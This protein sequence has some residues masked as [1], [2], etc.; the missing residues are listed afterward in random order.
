MLPNPSHLEAI[1]P[2]Q[3]GIV[4]ALQTYK[5]ENVL[6]IQ[7]HGDAAFSGQ[8]VV[9]ETLQMSQLAG[10]GVGGT[11]HLIVNNQLGYTATAELGRSARYASAPARMIGAPILH[12]NGDC[13]EEVARA[14]SIAIQ[15]QQKFAR[16]VII[17]LIC[18]RRHGHNELDEPFFTQPVMYKKIRGRPSLPLAYSEELVQ[19]DMMTLDEVQQV[20]DMAFKRLDNALQESKSFIPQVKSIR[21]PSDCSIE[22]WIAKRHFLCRRSSQNQRRRI[23]QGC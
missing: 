18:Y 20:R 2:V 10:Y 9:Q 13:P 14:C 7:I 15:Y 5:E 16:D 1:N 17:D 8:G 3:Q 4:Y 6:G 11:V 23:N 22:V 21:R 12:V 19:Q